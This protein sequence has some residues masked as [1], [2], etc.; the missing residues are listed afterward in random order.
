MGKVEKEQRRRLEQLSASQQRTTDTFE[1]LNGQ[2]HN[3]G[4]ESSATASHPVDFAAMFDSFK[5]AKESSPSTETTLTME[6]KRRLASQQ[7]SPS[8]L[9]PE[10]IAPNSG[11]ADDFMAFLGVSPRPDLSKI[12]AAPGDGVVGSSFPMFPQPPKTA[13]N[14]VQRTQKPP[15]DLDSLLQLTSPA[16]P[17]AFMPFPTQLSSAFNSNASSSQQKVDLSAF[18]RLVVF[19]QQAVSGQTPLPATSYAP[20]LDSLMGGMFGQVSGEED[21]KKDPLYGLLT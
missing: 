17:S 1:I 10:T 2:S 4:S 6:E 16:P 21:K 14:L 5:N 19:P 12:S 20:S 11:G 18:D 7:A 3:G 15:G 8:T 9:A 13:S